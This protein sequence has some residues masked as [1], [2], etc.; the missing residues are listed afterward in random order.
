MDNGLV[1]ILK[2]GEPEAFNSLVEEFQDKVI[3]TCYG[4]LHNKEDAEDTAQEVFIEVYRSINR[5]K[6]ESRLSTWIYRI[7]VSK[8]LDALKKKNRKKRFARIR[9]LFSNESP[10]EEVFESSDLNPEDRLEFNERSKILKQALDSLAENQRIAITLFQ[11]EGYS[12]IDIAE[13]MGT[14]LSAVESL[15]HR[16]KKNLQKKLTHYYQKK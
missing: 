13:I 14:T 12:Y 9:G 3:N 2:S 8:S 15:I 5:F 6:E 7:A 10:G 16:A 11:Y 1:S 4:F